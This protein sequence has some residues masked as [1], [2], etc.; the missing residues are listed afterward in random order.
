MGV[1]LM[2]L[3]SAD[4]GMYV[5]PCAKKKPFT[6][7]LVAD[8][9]QTSPETPIV[10]HVGQ[11]CAFFGHCMIPFRCSR[12]TSVGFEVLTSF[13]FEALVTESCVV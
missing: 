4:Q 7:F 13:G 9:G 8:F 1:S 2:S 12:W 11:V 3:L 5:V 10:Y 6:E